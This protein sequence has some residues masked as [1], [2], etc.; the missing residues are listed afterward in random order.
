MSTEYSPTEFLR[1]ASHTAEHFGFKT[2]T[3]LRKNQECKDCE[4][5]LAHSIT[6][7]DSRLDAAGGLLTRGLE[8]F[9]NENL[10]AIEAPILLYSIDKT[11]TD[12]T[13]VAFHIFNVPKS[14]AEAILIQANRALA[15]E[16][17]YGEHVVRINSLGDTDSMTRYIRELTNFLRKRLETMPAEAR[18]L[19]KQH[20]FIALQYLIE[21][22][23]ELALKSPNPLEFLSDQSRKHFRDIIE[24]L[25]MSETPYEIDSKM[26]GNHEYYSDALFSIE[27]PLEADGLKQPISM[28]GGR[29]D[30]YV[31][32]KTRRRTPAVGAVAIL[33]N[34][35]SPS[36]APRFKLQTP[37][38]YIIQLGFGPKI[39]SLLIIDELRRVGIS[40]YQDLANDSL[41]AQLRDAENLGV[42]YVIIIGQKEFV[43]DTV[44]LRDM[45]ARKQEP[46][47]HDVLIRKLKRTNQTT[48]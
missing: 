43:D 27:L 25:D 44:I 21:Q 39:R 13:A 14:I 45:E 22:N 38:V 5:T 23:H 20:P 9:C 47:N 34:K 15:T 48:V 2:I 6:A 16:L 36:R 12:E 40:V 4:I 11:D 31:E 29:F 35:P 33:H 26:L 32:R 7:E 19:M 17:G 42:K 46:V 8:I 41:S 37:M 30:E 10:H 18:E 24:Y 28:H 3:A 1:I